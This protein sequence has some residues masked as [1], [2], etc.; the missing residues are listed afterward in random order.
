MKHSEREHLKTNEVA[1]ALERLTG[2]Q[3]QSILR[4]VGIA[5][6][7]VVAIGA[8]VAWRGAAKA[9]AEGLLAEALRVESAQVVPPPAPGQPAAPAG[10]FQTEQARRDAALGKFLAV[11]EAYPSSDAGIT[12]RFKAGALLAEQGKRS[13]ALAAFQAVAAQ[14]GS[15]IHARMAALAVAEL[16]LAAGQHEAAIA[17]FRELSTRKDT[18]LPADGVLMQLGRA[19]RMAGKKAEALQT[20]TRVTEEFPQSIYVGEAR[21]EADALKASM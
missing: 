10:S 6:V 7:V 17:A 18:D 19:Y 8:F 12:A 3:G 11:A 2:V 14:G 20:F 16:Q 15:S 1:V 5:L 13:E 4:I 9:K 21:R